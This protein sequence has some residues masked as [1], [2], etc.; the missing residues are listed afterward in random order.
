MT[1]QAGTTAELGGGTRKGECFLVQTAM[2]SSC[3]SRLGDT[4]KFQAQWSKQTSSAWRSVRNSV[5]SLTGKILLLQKTDSTTE[6]NFLFQIPAF[7]RMT[8][9]DQCSKT[10]AA[11]LG[12]TLLAENST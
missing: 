2:L 6:E 9:K 10:I 1:E 11:C 3:F 8:N 7:Q 5:L 4:L 12:V